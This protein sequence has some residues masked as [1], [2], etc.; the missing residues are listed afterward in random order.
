MW[1]DHQTADQCTNRI[2]LIVRWPGITDALAGQEQ[3]ALH[4]HLDLPATLVSLLGVE[5]PK[6]WDGESFAQSLSGPDSGRD[7]LILSQGAWSCQRSVRWDKWLLIRTY[8]TGLKHFPEYM[9]YDIEADPHETS[10]LAAQRP[11]ILGHGLRLMDQWLGEQM[12]RSMRGDPFW[13]VIQEGGPLHANVHRQEWKD[14][15]ARLRQ[16]GRGHFADLLD[17]FEGKPFTTGLEPEG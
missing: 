1:G 15:I 7:F 17:K 4:Y 13:G 14:Y 9:L 5:Q 11:E 3:S 12:S 8:H 2:P 6:N 10:N 16:T